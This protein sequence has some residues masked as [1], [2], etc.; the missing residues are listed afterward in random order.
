MNMRKLTLSLLTMAV[1]TLGA[2]AQERIPDPQATPQDEKPNL[3]HQLGLTPDQT[4]QVR[5]LN[6][7]RK[8]MMEEA[9]RRVRA[10]NQ[11]LDAAIYADNVDEN[12]VKARLNELQQAQFEVARI[13]F[14]NELAIRKILTAEQLG[15]FRE[16]RRQFADATRDALKER[17]QERINQRRNGGAP[18]DGQNKNLRQLIRERNQQNRPMK[19]PPPGQVQPKPKN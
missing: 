8:P 7:Q 4:R 17:R 12:D 16:L 9:Q 11:A 18:I 14:T 1:L 5:Q 15:H 10:A 19:S 2:L 6:Q 3:L 13:R